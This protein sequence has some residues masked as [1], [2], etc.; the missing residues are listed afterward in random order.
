MKRKRNFMLAT[1]FVAV[2]GYGAYSVPQN[3][4]ISDVALAN[5]EALASGEGSVRDC[6]FPSSSDCIL[7]D[8]IDSSKDQIVPNRKWAN[9]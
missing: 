9:S 3:E 8:P 7:L 1:A 5:I 4:T 6:I 2:A